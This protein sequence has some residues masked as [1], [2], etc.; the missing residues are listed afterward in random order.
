MKKIYLLPLLLF[1]FSCATLESKYSP[2]DPYRYRQLAQKKE[3]KETKE[4]T[5]VREYKQLDKEKQLDKIPEFIR[6]ESVDNNVVLTKNDM[7]II[8][9]FKKRYNIVESIDTM[10][11]KTVYAV[12]EIR[13]KTN[14]NVSVKDVL[15]RINK[16]I[17]EMGTSSYVLAITRTINSWE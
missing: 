9:E 3:T 4:N 5:P 8:S 14:K 2:K 16:N 12:R 15:N 1:V 13:K 17:R 10:Q 11:E 6:V 7:N